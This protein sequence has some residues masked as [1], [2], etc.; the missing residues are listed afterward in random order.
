M[1]WLLPVRLRQPKLFAFIIAITEPIRNYNYKRVRT[2][3]LQ[4]WYDLK[5]QTGQVAY[6]EYVL[7][8]K[9]DHIQKRIWIGKGTQPQQVYIYVHTESHPLY[10]YTH[11]E[12]QPVYIYTHSENSV[13]QTYFDFTVNVPKGLTFA[14]STI[15]AAIDRY[16]RDGKSYDYVLF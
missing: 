2:W 8:D 13:T 16:K 15:K 11:A 9:F 6:L 4:C 7:N 1:R 10:I 3:E 12:Q 5:Y 14:D